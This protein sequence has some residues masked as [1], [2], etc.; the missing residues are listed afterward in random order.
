M[1]GT[2]VDTYMPKMRICTINEHLQK[3]KLNLIIS[4]MV[5]FVHVERTQILII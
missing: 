4:S 2:N 5:E 3:F 1:E